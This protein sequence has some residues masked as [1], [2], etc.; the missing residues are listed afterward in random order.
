MTVSVL[1]GTLSMLLV[2][3]IICA[4]S[5]L[6]MAYPLAWEENVAK[7]FPQYLT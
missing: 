2:V 1:R 5:S 4:D 7:L 3:K 6:L